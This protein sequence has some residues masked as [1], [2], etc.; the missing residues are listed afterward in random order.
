MY[1]GFIAGAGRACVEFQSWYFH[2]RYTHAF[3]L[4]T[5]DTRRVFLCVAM[6]RVCF[7][8]VAFCPLLPTIREMKPSLLTPQSVLLLYGL[9]LPIFDSCYC[10]SSMLDQNI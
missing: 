2:S 10:K 5:T 4:F 7:E 9:D 1:C 3:V 6:F 8:H